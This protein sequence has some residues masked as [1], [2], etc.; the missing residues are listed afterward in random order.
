[1]SALKGLHGHGK[2]GTLYFQKQVDVIRRNER[3]EMTSVVGGMTMDK[4][5]ADKANKME[6]LTGKIRQSWAGARHV[7]PAC[8]GAWVK[9][10][11]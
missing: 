1:M 6:A 3:Q 7:Q 2:V 8:P 4:A 11:P 10:S 9:G 5:S